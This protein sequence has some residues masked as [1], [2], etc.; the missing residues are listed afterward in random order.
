MSQFAAPASATGIDWSTLN[1]ALLIIDVTEVVKDINTNF[2][3]TNAVRATVT[4]VDGAKAGDE[5]ADTLVFPK[6][7]Q[8]QLSP[9]IGKTV[10]GRLGQGL[11]KPGQSA[12]WTLTEANPADQT[13]AANFVAARAA[14]QLTAD[15]I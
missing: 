4:V 9:L 12:P 1:G 2:G 8:S 6:M 7:L 13:T 10:L 11:A 3:T 5:Y 14:N 15:D